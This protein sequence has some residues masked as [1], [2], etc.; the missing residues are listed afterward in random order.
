ML[1]RA[2]QK[3]AIKHNQAAPQV[4]GGVGRLAPRIEQT[5]AVADL[6]RLTCEHPVQFKGR[7]RDNRSGEHGT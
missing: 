2:L 4:G 5:G 3:I 6:D 7:A 1:A